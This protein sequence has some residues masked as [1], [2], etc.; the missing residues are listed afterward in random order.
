M[1][2]HTK[3]QRFV[4]CEKHLFQMVY[5]TS[6]VEIL[7]DSVR[8]KHDNCLQGI[9]IIQNLISFIEIL[10]DSVEVKHNNCWQ[11]VQIIQDD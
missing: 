1:I 4:S 5:P 3:F 10:L 2:V 11:G 9:Q 7:L 8:I 6:F